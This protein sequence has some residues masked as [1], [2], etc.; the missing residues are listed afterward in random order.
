M[1]AALEVESLPDGAGLIHI[2]MPKTGTT[3]LQ[4]ALNDARPTLESSGVHNVGRRRHEM[5]TALT[6]AGALPS[7]WG[8]KWQRRW[9]A[10]AED[11]RTSPARCVLWSSESL[12]QAKPD[13]I[14]HI[15]DSLGRDSRVLITLRPLAPLLASQWQEVLR[16]RGTDPLDVWLHRHF[17]SVSVDGTVH[18]TWTRVMP[19]LHRFSLRRVVEQWGAVFGEE[20]LIF[21]VP[22]PQDRTLN[23][24]TV[25]R[26]VG[27][28]QDT[29]ALQHRDN[30]SLPYPEAEM[31]RHFN[32]VYTERGGDHATWMFT[33]GGG[34]GRYL[35]RQLTDL[36]PHPIRTPRWAAERANEHTEA[37]IEA[38]A[39]SRATVV[40]DLA[41]LLVDPAEH[42]ADERAPTAVSVE[43]AGRLAD[44]L[45][46]V[47]LGYDAP[48]TTTSGPAPAPPK[49]IGDLPA[50]DL[51][52]EL[53]RRARRR[54]DPRGR[55]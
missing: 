28:P 38:V 6:A 48:E 46:Q 15:A 44:V 22:P 50:R 52:R 24:R 16:R 45:F 39:G 20:N 30:A 21:V 53:G 27:V 7:Y 55:K 51:V 49:E 42:P 9:T 19:V 26:L 12:S 10:L 13:R 4:A 43:S 36:D 5:N 32:R 29:L 11:F 18:T 31:L 25:E 17:D 33:V 23:L 8:D 2:G 14:Q 41:D 35:L 54:I 37:W 47:A 40:G 3:A 34:P 1:E